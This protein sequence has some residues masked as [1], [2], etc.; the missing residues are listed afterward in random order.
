VNLPAEIG[1]LDKRMVD[2]GGGF[3]LPTNMAIYKK[4][5]CLGPRT[6]IAA[7]RVICD[8]DIAT[9]AETGTSLIHDPAATLNRG[10]G[11]PSISKVRRAGV[12]V[13]L[14]TNALGQDIFEAMR[15]AGWIARTVDRVAD[16]L[17]HKVA[18]EMATIR[19]AEIFGIDDQVG[20][21]EVGKKADVITVNLNKVH[22]SPCLNVTAAT[23]LC[24]WGG[25]VEEVILNGTMAVKQG[26]FVNF[27]ETA[28]IKEANERALF[29]AKKAGLHD[30]L[31]P[32]V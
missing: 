22:H 29:C 21:L 15:V 16:A 13:G 19:N 4:Y 20:S 9:L 8:E 24:A 3:P 2:E 32:L 5:G 31:L 30:R 14:C 26:K 10:L 28:I 11:M 7:M 25:D 1:F 23:A 6:I 12:R 18:L 27:D 17:P